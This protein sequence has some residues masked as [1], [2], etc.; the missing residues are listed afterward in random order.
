[1][2]FGKRKNLREGDMT[3]YDYHCE[4]GYF[5]TAEKEGPLLCP[6]CGKSLPGEKQDQQ[7]PRKN[8]SDSLIEATFEV[9]AEEGA[10]WSGAR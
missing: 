4:C 6:R 7:S 8:L 10:I 1:M 9:M 3:A 2:D 5:F